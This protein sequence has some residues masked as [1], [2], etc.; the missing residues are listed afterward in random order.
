[1]ALTVRLNGSQADKLI[2]L[3]KEHKEKIQSGEITGFGQSVQREI[4]DW[5]LI[6]YALDDDDDDE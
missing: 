4:D 2:E 1:M 5:D 3:V 6:L